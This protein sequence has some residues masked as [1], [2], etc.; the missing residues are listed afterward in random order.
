MKI[1]LAI[2]LLVTLSSFSSGTN[3]SK[4]TNDVN[5]TAYRATNDNGTPTILTDDVHA[6]FNTL[7]CINAFIASHP[8]YV[9]NGKVSVPEEWVLTCI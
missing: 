9:K 1:L 8:G 3:H 2:V 4:S 6:Y 7:A 5:V